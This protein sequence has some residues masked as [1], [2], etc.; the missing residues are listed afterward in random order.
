[1]TT[2]QLLKKYGTAAEVARVFGYTPAAIS[3]WIKAKRIPNKAQRMIEL[4]TGGELKAK[5]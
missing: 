4:M 2:N 5:P 1:M 3:L